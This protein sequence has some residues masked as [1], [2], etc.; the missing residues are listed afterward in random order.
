MSFNWEIYRELNPDLE[1]AGLKT[2]QD[3]ERHYIIHCKPDKRNYSLYQVYPDFDL[4]IYRSKNS[5]LSNFSDNMLELHWLKHGRHEN[6]IYRKDIHIN[7][8]ID[9]SVFNNIDKILY[10]NLEHRKD[11]N[12]EINE[13]FKRVG[14]SQDKIIRIDAIY[15]NPGSLGCSAS[16]I[17]CLE[18]AISN[19]YKNVLILEDDFNFIDNIQLIYDYLQHINNVNYDVI[20]L[21]GNIIETKKYNDIFNKV[22]NVQTTSGYIVNSNYYNKLL[23]NY[24]KGLEFLKQTKENTIYALDIYWKLLQPHD[25]W[26]IFNK[27]IGY[28][29]PSYSDIEKKDVDYIGYS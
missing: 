9:N 19:N 29:R 6:R 27:T 18:Y 17:K 20:L 13:Q 11:R 25:K 23:E 16:H 15:D 12:N 21:A 5:D 26:Y 1:K 3:F 28:Q 4:N 22:I 8:I 7:N 2:K 10:I 14:I 24:K